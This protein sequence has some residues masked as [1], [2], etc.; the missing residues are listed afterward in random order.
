MCQDLRIYLVVKQDISSFSISDS[1]IQYFANV[2]FPLLDV[3]PTSKFEWKIL[4]QS[5]QIYDIID[6]F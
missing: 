4:C 3:L 2:L 1:I 6:D 5:F